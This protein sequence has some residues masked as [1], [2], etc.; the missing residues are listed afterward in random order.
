MDQL[1]DVNQQL[2]DTGE[3][4]DEE[5]EGEAAG[6]SPN[7]LTEPGASSSRI[8]FSTPSPTKSVLSPSK[9]HIVCH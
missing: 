1:N 4:M 3:V 9:R 5:Q 6:S 2:G 8:K 7:Q